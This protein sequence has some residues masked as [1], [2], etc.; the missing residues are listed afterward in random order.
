M[1][2]VVPLTSADF[3]QLLWYASLFGVKS[4]FPDQTP[5]LQLSC[6]PDVVDGEFSIFNCTV[7]R[8]NYPSKCTHTDNDA[9]QFRFTKEGDTRVWCEVVGIQTQNCST[10]VLPEIYVTQSNETRING[11]HREVPP[12]FARVCG[13]V[14]STNDSYTLQFAIEHSQYTRVV[15]GK[16]DCQ[17]PSCQNG[18]QKPAMLASSSKACVKAGAVTTTDKPTVSTFTDM[19][20]PRK[21]SDGVIACPTLALVVSAS[22]ACLVAL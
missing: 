10:L 17:I 5:D 1:P 6:P 14:A 2:R 12:S 8:E 18:I 21:A 13:C 20:T 11:T 9:A 7:R 15:G 16:W 4:E 3:L 22:V 19:S